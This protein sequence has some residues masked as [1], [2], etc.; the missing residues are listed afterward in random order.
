MGPLLFICPGEYSGSRIRPVS[1][2]SVVLNI[3][4]KRFQRAIV[5]IKKEP[6]AALFAVIVAVGLL[7]F[8]VYP[9][10]SI[11]KESFLDVSGQ[12]IGFKNYTRFL[13]TH[14]FHRV[15]LNT[16]LITTASTA[17]ALTVGLLFSYGIARTDM[18]GRG[19][20]KIIAILPMITP[21]FINAFALV[22]LFGRRGIIN[23]LLVAAFGFKFIIYG[24]H[25][26]VLSQIMTSFPLAYLTL[27]AAFKSLDP[28][29][30]DSAKDLGARNLRV[31]RTVTLPMITPAI[32]T[33]ALMVYMVNLAAFGAP[34]LLGRGMSVLAVEI[35]HQVL[36]IFDW[37]IGTV[38]C[39]VLLIPSALLFYFQSVYKRKQSYVSV[40]GAPAHYEAKKTPGSIKWPIFGFCSLFSLLIMSVWTVVI[41]GGFTK[42]WGADNTLVLSHYTMIFSTTWRSIVNT[43]WMASLGALLASVIGLV[44]AYILVRRTF[45]GKRVMDFL[46]TL[47]YAV[48]GS[49]MGLGL[50]VAFNRNPLVLTGTAT[51]IV[52]CFVIRRM[53]FA[54]RSGAATL[55]QIDE[56]IEEA[57]ADLG[58]KWFYTF[59]K[60]VFPLMKPAFIG[61]MTFAFIRTATE[62]TSTIFL[63][64]PRWRVMSVDIYNMVSAGSLGSAAA[65]ST[66]LMLF[67]VV[68]LLIFYKVSGVSPSEFKM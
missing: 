16:L 14:Y 38:L 25:G 50:V 61:G 58:G 10:Y 18:P 5:D 6:V 7:I 29:F 26:V 52:L 62:L 47:P 11:L 23:E 49:L 3:S 24:W 30:E 32:L 8:V 45:P 46:A 48:P 15:F 1:E 66:I 44:V 28:S 35:V 57:S 60:I 12:F 65:L 21:P 39:V 31:L 63:V 51:I 9:L 27:S 56:T 20:F 68:T 2:V 67:I 64:T 42:T 4:S 17:G 55:K 43:A 53:P 40:T 13:T 19:L 33:S 34:A 59:R 41:F 22:L 54:L 37:G 36:G